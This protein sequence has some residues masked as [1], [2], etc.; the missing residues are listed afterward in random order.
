MTPVKN[1]ETIE[2]LQYKGLRIIQN[3]AYFCFGMDAVLL[4]GFTSLSRGDRV[5]DLCT[6]TGIVPILLSG[7]EKAREIVGVELMPEVAD[8]AKRSVA[9]NGLQDKIKILKGDVKQA[10]KDIDGAFDVVT[11][12]PPYEKSNGSPQSP[13]TYLEAARHEVYLDFKDV[14]KAANRMLKCGGKLF[15]IHRVPRLP[16]LL[17]TL[18]Q[19]KLEPKRMRLVCPAVNKAPN[20][21]LIEAVKDGREG[22]K[23]DPV[24]NVRDESGA[25]TK[26]INRIYHRDEE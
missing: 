18:K 23:V 12:N 20:L 7:Q 13:N 5:L 8:M 3:K 24:L 2:D 9:L 11:V 15:L 16:E 19:Y 6:G 1:K 25:Y 22:L 4:A 21:V 17:C 14:C 26:E 10:Y